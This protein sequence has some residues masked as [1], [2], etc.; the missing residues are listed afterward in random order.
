MPFWGTYFYFIMD[1][2]R[3]KQKEA[4]NNF[5]KLKKLKGEKFRAALIEITLNSKTIEEEL[6][7]VEINDVSLINHDLFKKRKS[8]VLSFWKEI[9][10]KT[11]GRV[12]FHPTDALIIPNKI[13]MLDSK[14]NRL[15]NL[16]KYSKDDIFELI[17][18]YRMLFESI[19][20]FEYQLRVQFQTV[21]IFP[22]PH[23]LKIFF[24]L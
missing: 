9:W 21:I 14:L 18:T 15:G 2:I 22:I 1:P 11:K 3:K 5:D 20:Q 10:E 23:I 12:K 8:I 17:N 16:E 4:L 19:Q 13:L 7:F 24:N 6:D